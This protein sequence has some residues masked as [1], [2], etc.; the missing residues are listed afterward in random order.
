M[1]KV[2]KSKSTDYNIRTV[3]IEEAKAIMRKQGGCEAY[4]EKVFMPTEEK[5]ASLRVRSGSVFYKFY[6]DCGLSDIGRVKICI[7]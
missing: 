3:S 5:L 7:T 6:L 4:V 2:S 1:L